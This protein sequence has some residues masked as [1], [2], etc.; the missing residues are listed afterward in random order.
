ML[1]GVLI[2]CFV[3]IGQF[4]QSIYPC[5]GV[6]YKKRGW[7]IQFD[8][9]HMQLVYRLNLLTTETNTLQ[10]LEGLTAN[11]MWSGPTCQ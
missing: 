6:K 11:D 10:Y 9:N 3:Y 5:T 4:R 1:N 8:G 2:S 7:Y